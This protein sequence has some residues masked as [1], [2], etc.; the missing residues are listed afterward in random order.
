[1]G[2][3]IKDAIKGCD[4]RLDDLMKALREPPT[5]ETCCLLDLPSVYLRE[6]ESLRRREKEWSAH[7]GD[8]ET[9]LEVRTW[10]AVCARRWTALAEWFDDQSL[11]RGRLTTRRDN[12]RE[13]LPP[14]TS[15]PWSAI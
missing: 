11:G 7:P 14:A 10:A 13:A 1:M 12:F 9:V 2:V 4:D 3:R 5:E 6:E 15:L 8:E